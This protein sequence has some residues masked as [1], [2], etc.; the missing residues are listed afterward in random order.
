MA[1]SHTLKME[2]V[3]PTVPTV[4]VCS[5]HYAMFPQANHFTTYTHCPNEV[6]QL[7]HVIKGYVICAHTLHEGFPQHLMESAYMMTLSRNAHCTN[8]YTHL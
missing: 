4:N 5:L 6:V 8:I 2:T 1:Y 3:R 7:S